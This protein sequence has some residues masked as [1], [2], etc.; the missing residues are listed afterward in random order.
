MPGQGR[1]C[2][3]ATFKASDL[4][5]WPLRRL[6][7]PGSL[8]TTGQIGRDTPLDRLTGSTTFPGKD[9]GTTTKVTWDIRHVGPILLPRQPVGGR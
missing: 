1:D 8:V 9:G 2:R 6:A 7:T 4:P 5:A 3:E